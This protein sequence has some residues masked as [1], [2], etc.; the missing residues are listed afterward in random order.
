[1]EK[2]A[3]RVSSSSQRRKRVPDEDRHVGRRQ[4]LRGWRQ[5]KELQ[6]NESEKKTAVREVKCP[7]E[8]WQGWPEPILRALVHCHGKALGPGSSGQRAV[9]AEQGYK[10]LLPHRNPQ[11]IVPRPGLS[12]GCFLFCFLT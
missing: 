10:L 9:S 4:G 3:S 5:F 8:S 2:K 1:M 7:R 11:K 6:G 12:H